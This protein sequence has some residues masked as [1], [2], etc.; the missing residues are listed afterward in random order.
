MARAA[1]ELRGASGVVAAGRSVAGARERNEDAFAIVPD[2][3]LYVVSDGVGGRPGGDTA[4]QIVITAV[5]E[6]LCEALAS[7][8]PTEPELEQV[9]VASLARLS[10][11]VRREAP[12]WA[13]QAGMGATVVLAVIRS[14]RLT[15]AHAGDSRAYLFHR[16]QL[17]RL[18][19]DH[20]V[21]G[22][23][24]DQRAITEEEATDHPARGRITRYIGMEDQ[25]DADVASVDF[26]RG[27]RLLLC[28]DGLTSV[29]HDDAVA[30]LLG[31]PDGTPASVCRGLV[32]AALDTGSSDNVTALIAERPSG[33]VATTDAPRQR[34]RKEVR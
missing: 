10:D 29:V 31:R 23:L 19:A 12:H 8:E 24:L 4:S 13:G 1:D 32:R 28:T 5:P 25:L 2:L 18:T 15:I 16:G 20:S 9:L 14:D 22:I 33:A 30:D 11:T 17:S 6:L 7:G 3:D 26:D 21:V 27:D 34:R